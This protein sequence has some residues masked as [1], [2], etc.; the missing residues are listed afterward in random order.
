MTIRRKVPVILAFTLIGLVAAILVTSRLLL[1]DS[2]ARL[3]EQEVY[4]HLQRA[5]NA[6][7]D[8]LECLNR[9]LA[10]YANWDTTYDFMATHD[11]KYPEIELRNASLI[12]LRMNFVG[13][14]DLTGR[15]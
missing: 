9:T 5:V 7:S 2:F 6:L 11:G 8:D 15:T 4:L 10:D 3:E 13:I 14:F 1:I 12:G